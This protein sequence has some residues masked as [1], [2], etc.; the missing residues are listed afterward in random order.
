MTKRPAR[1]EPVF[2]TTY[3]PQM[4]TYPYVLAPGDVF[5]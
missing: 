2:F 1:H 5:C 4:T 3:A